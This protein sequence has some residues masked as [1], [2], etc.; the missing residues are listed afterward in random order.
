MILKSFGCSFIFGTDLNDDGPSQQTWPALIAKKQNYE[1]QCYALPGI[2]NL[3]IL[4]TIIEQSLKNDPSLFV[5][6]WSW[7]DRFDFI[8]CVDD[9]W[10]TLLPSNSISESEYYYKNLHSQY[11]DKLT[12]LMYVH[13]AINTLTEKN[14][15]FVMTYMD[16]LLFETEW[17]SN[18]VIIDLQK[19]IKPHLKTFSGKNFLEW[20]IEHGYKI[21]KGNHP[22]EDAHLAAAN[23]LN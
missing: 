6:N 19:K 9:S 2:G 11:Y 13:T 23:Y 17:H 5:I 21:S 10:K 3:R 16:N 8:T 20:S 4:E 7:I 12:N 22:L 15:P 18:S 14:I 1:Y